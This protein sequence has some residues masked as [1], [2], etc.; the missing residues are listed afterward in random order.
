MIL[1][2]CSNCHKGF[3]PATAKESELVFRGRCYQRSSVQ[4]NIL[5]KGYL[6]GDCWYML[7]DGDEL[8]E[9]LDPIEMNGLTD[10]E[11]IMEGLPLPC[12]P[13]IPSLI[14]A[15]FRRFLHGPPS[16]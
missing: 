6:C 13:S 15:V 10:D 7:S 14:K 16:E 9:P 12:R 3:P 4:N 8:A 5:L 11:L 1:V 2:E